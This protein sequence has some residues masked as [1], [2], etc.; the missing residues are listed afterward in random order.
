MSK[1]VVTLVQSSLSS[2]VSTPQMEGWGIFLSASEFVSSPSCLKLQQCDVMRPSP[3]SWCPQLTTNTSHL[4]VLPP[5]WLGPT[6]MTSGGQITGSNHSKHEIAI[7]FSKNTH[8]ISCEDNAFTKFS[9]SIKWSFLS[10]FTKRFA[11]SK[12]RD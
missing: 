2:T 8:C 6:T 4:P 11:W 9:W 1:S 5:D 10:I 12:Y 7:C 3:S